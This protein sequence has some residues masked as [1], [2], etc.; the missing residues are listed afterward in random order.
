VARY[1]GTGSTDDATNFTAA[2]PTNPVDDHFP[3][4]GHFE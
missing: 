3:W 2:K 1:D 4:L